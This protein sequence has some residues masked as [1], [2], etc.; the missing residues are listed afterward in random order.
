MMSKRVSRDYKTCAHDWV[1]LVKARAYEMFQRRPEVSSDADT[2]W[3]LV[4]LHMGDGVA[5]V[6]SM[7]SPRLNGYVR[8]MRVYQTTV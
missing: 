4:R 7:E 1:Q 6:A 8:F 2:A 3:L 5:Q